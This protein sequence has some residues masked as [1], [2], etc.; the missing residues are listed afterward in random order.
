MIF[1]LTRVT[2][3]GD[4]KASMTFSQGLFALKPDQSTPEAIASFTAQIQAPFSLEA[5]LLEVTPY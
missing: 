2:R 4:S 3:I 1:M 5:N